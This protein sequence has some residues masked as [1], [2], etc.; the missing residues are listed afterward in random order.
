MKIVAETENGTTYLKDVNQINFFLD[1]MEMGDEILINNN[2]TNGKFG[3]SINRAFF[4]FTVYKEIFYFF[5]GDV[6]DS[7]VVF[8]KDFTSLNEV[9]KYFANEN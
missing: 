9:K 5:Q 1:T 7:Q 3:Y 2:G 8:E 6:E 4:G